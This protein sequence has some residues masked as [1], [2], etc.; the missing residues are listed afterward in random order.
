[1]RGECKF[2][3]IYIANGDSDARAVL[4]WDWVGSGLG[5]V[6]DCSGTGWGLGGDWVGT[7]WG[8]VGAQ[9]FFSSA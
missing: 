4:V 9:K 3:D 8:P 1:M 6:G 7:G 5:P 2:A